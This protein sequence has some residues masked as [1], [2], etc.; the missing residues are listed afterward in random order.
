[1]NISTLFKTVPKKVEQL[2]LH[3]ERKKQTAKETAC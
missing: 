1:M 3:K 2:L